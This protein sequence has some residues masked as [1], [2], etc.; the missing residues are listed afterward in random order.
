MIARGDEL[1]FTLDI[2]TCISIWGG[3]FKPEDKN[4]DAILIKYP[5][6][7]L[8]Y[9]YFCHLTSGVYFGGSIHILSMEDEITNKS[10]TNYS[11]LR[12]LVT[13]E[14]ISLSINLMNA[15]NHRSITR[16][17]AN[18]PLFGH[19]TILQDKK[20]RFWWSIKKKHSTII[21][22]AACHNKCHINISNSDNSIT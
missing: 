13:R 22:Y 14:A 16:L 11:K 7:C 15:S 2:N 12:H 4:A 9:C 20:I 5:Q 17:F 3:I 1:H 10:Y 18:M 6:T 19:C 21:A 8:K